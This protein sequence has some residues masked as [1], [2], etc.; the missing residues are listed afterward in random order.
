MSEALPIDDPSWIPPRKRLAEVLAL[1][2]DA[3]DDERAEVAA[4][5]LLRAQSAGVELA[6]AALAKAEGTAAIR[7][8]RLLSRAREPSVSKPVAAA[9]LARVADADDRVARAAVSAIG[10]LVRAN[11]PL[12]AEIETALLARRAEAAPPLGRAIVEALGKLGS[13]AALEALAPVDAKAAAPDAGGALDE[14]TAR[15]RMRLERTVAR[16]ENRGSIDLAARL[17]FATPIAL[18]VRAGLE[19]IAVR[20]AAVAGEGGKVA[21]KGR[22]ESVAESSLARWTTLRLPMRLLLPLPAPRVPT[23]AAAPDDPAGGAR[24]EAEIEAAIVSAMASASTTGPVAALTRGPWRYRIE[25]RGQGPR[26]A[27]TLRLATAIARAEPRWANDPTDALWELEVDLGAR[28]GG[29]PWLALFPRGAADERFAYRHR[30]V[31]AA[32][33]PT[34][35]AALAFV[36][37][38]RADDVVWDPFVGSGRELLERARLGPALALF[39]SDLDRRAC[40]IARENLAQTPNA[41]LL[42]GDATTLRLPQRPTLVLSNP[43]MGR[44][45]LERAALPALFAATLRNVTEQLADGGRLVWLS[46]LFGQTADLGVSL[47]LRLIERSRVDLGGFD[48]ELQHFEKPPAGPPQKAGRARG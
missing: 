37:G 3:D 33:H 4:R 38:V 15:A 25:W 7:L 21:G 28:R 31:P 1:V 26:R 24:D 17:P 6:V 43:P 42:E 8:A 20:E 44:R 14:S 29:R 47:G 5:A 45:V 16:A 12:A 39:G 46:P 23:R 36:G 34:L 11:H 48:A 2:V 35:A 27:A 18:E 30:D 22:V 41:T 9:L 19:A 10:R 32:S 40:A 13:S